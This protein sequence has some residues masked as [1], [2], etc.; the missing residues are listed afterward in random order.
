MKKYLNALLALLLFASIT[1]DADARPR[2]GRRGQAR[3]A[4]RPDTTAPAFSGTLLLTAGDTQIILDFPDGDGTTHHYEVRVN[5]DSTTSP[6]NCASGTTVTGCSDPTASTCTATGLTNMTSYAFIV[7]AADATGNTSAGLTAWTQPWVN[8]LA[9]SFG[10]T[11]DNDIATVNTA[12]ASCAATGR[13]TMCEWLDHPNSTAPDDVSAGLVDAT[14]HRYVIGITETGA[15]QYLP[16]GEWNGFNNFVRI[17]PGVDNRGVYWQYC[18]SI[19]T[20]Q[21]TNQA[22]GKG[23]L[24]RRGTPLDGGVADADFNFHQAFLDGGIDGGTSQL[25]YGG[26]LPSTLLTDAGTDPSGTF[27]IGG[28][29]PPV[30]ALWY[31]G[32]ADE[33]VIW[34]EV[35]NESQLRDC[36]RSDA[37]DPRGAGHPVNIRTDPDCI[38]QGMD[39]PLIYIRHGE[40]DT[41]SSSASLVSRGTASIT[42]ASSNFE[43]SECTSTVP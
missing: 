29:L 6:A 17:I 36:T 37:S 7:C 40:G 43:G 21:A 1:L 24:G 39:T 8:A 33:L 42:V 20:A 10:G 27:V 18:F 30:T 2:R 5:A 16:Q 15:T 11:A 9:M 31:E 38:A 14:N 3:V 23:Y 25:A 12:A 32:R 26:T 34:C 28:T 4:K 19:D 35:Y 13:M 22:K 41:C